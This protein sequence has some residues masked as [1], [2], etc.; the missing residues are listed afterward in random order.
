MLTKPVGQLR[1]FD[2]AS[3]EIEYETLLIFYK[4]IDLTAVENQER[5][6]GGV[7]DALVPSTNGWLRTSEKPRTAALS[8]SVGYRST[9]PNVALGWA[10]ADSRA[11]KSRMPDAPPVA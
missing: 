5:L 2:P 8:I 7:A 11:P 1:T 3:G 6:H 4:R 10:I 9:P